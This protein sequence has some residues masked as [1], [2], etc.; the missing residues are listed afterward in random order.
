MTIE[1]KPGAPVERP[2]PQRGATRSGAL[3]LALQPREPRRRHSRHATRNLQVDSPVYGWVINFSEA[4]LCFESLSEL[5]TGP[6][7][8]FRLS[9]GTTFLHLP[10]RAIWSRFHRTQPTRKGTVSVYRTGIELAV[11]DSSVDWQQ[12]IA[13]LTG[14]AFV[15]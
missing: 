5:V 11:D 13:R 4:G 2:T 14:T 1:A 12:A 6:H 8:I 10:G 3:P 9:Y 15:S 7:Y